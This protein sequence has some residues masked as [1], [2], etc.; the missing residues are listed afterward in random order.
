VVVSGPGRSPGRRSFSVGCPGPATSRGC[1]GLRA[2][3]VSRAASSS[4]RPAPSAWR[5][6]E[7][8]LPARVLMGRLGVLRW[9]QES[10]ITRQ[11]S[12]GR[13]GIHKGFP[14]CNKKKRL[15]PP[16]DGATPCR[17]EGTQ[18]ACGSHGSGM[19]GASGSRHLGP[20]MNRAG[21]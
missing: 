15:E 5:K 4:S 8:R 11:F 14:L 21:G 19:A 16:L 10:H 12:P 7:G 6:A 18:L 1:C 20:G 13:P 2:G 17:G 3:C 9:P